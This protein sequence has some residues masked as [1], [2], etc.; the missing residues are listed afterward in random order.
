[1]AAKHIPTPLT[2]GPLC[3][4]CKGTGANIKKTLKIASWDSGYV[5]CWS[6]NG[7]G[8][9]PAELFRWGDHPPLSSTQTT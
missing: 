9:D 5:R 8:L 4:D 3:P 7:S 6:C 1:M 2:S